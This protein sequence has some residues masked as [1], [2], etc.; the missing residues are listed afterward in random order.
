M[1]TDEGGETAA[2]RQWLPCRLA[3]A[4]RDRHR[5]LTP[6]AAV[7]GAA[8][9]AL[10]LFGLPPVDLHGPL[11]Y[12]G[13]MGPACGGTRAMHATLTG[14]LGRAIEYNPL[15][16][17]LVLLG[18][19]AVLREAAGRLTG[20]WLNVHITR[21]RA[22]LTVS[23]VLLTALTVRQQAHAEFLRAGPETGVPTGLTLYAAVATPT[24]LGITAV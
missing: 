19:A 11:H 20:R 17:L 7:G 18:V 4:Q 21:P 16:P 13:V 2:S 23:L 1:S 15:S 8:A 9:V 24:V 14:D 6:L 12:A 5:W 10:A 22:A 3:L